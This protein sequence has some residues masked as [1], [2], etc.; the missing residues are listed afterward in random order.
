VIEQNVTV[1]RAVC[2]GCNTTFYSEDGIFPGFTGAI[3]YD[4]GAGAG[5]RVTWFAC[6]RT[7]VQKAV[8]FALAERE[9]T[10]QQWEQGTLQ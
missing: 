1:D 2:G 7:H 9:R 5:Y 3:V 8:R 10:Q 6:R 4:D